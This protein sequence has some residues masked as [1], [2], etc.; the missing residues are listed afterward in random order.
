M[1][2]LC[3]VIGTLTLLF[4]CSDGGG[5]SGYV[6]NPP[7]SGFKP[8]PQNPTVD[9]ENASVEQN[10]DLTG[11]YSRNTIQ[12][13]DYIDYRL[14][15]WDDFNPDVGEN[16]SRVDIADAALYL[17][18][19]E[20]S[21]AEIAEHFDGKRDLFHMA[22]YVINNA[23]N[24]CFDSGTDSATCFTE[25]R[26]SVPPY[27]ENISTEIRENATLL[28]ADGAVMNTVDGKEFTF[29]LDTNGTISGVQLTDADDVT[30]DFKQWHNYSVD[31]DANT[32]TLQNFSY[33][34]IGRELGLSY[35][36]FGRYKITSGV[37]NANT[38]QETG[39]TT[40]GM[41]AGG[42]ESKKIAEADIVIPDTDLVLYGR[43]AATVTSGRGSEPATA[44]FTGVSNL[45]MNKDSGAVELVTSFDNWYNVVATKNIGNNDAKFTFS[46]FAE[47]GI[48]LFQFA[49][50]V[51]GKFET[52]GKMD[53]NYYAENPE[54]N[55]PTEAT[56]LA[57]VDN[58]ADDV[59][60]D[61]VFGVKQQF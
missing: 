22:V 48:Y 57:T 32:A 9:F 18:N 41:F 23:L 5:T 61:M 28:T 49:D 37:L 53:I 29:F 13:T 12:I 46:N 52:T 39:S 11:L 27:F 4:G 56:G 8:R 58:G 10:N 55:L 26:D 24:H 25:W 59:K 14:N 51:D 33:D 45:Y 60:M 43:A 6:P 54:T 3:C 50:A 7:D 38:G 15:D 36:D 2:K 47:S 1:K 31:S 19:A 16:I 44:N 17:T 42:Y 35:S 40:T 20:L 21:A 30:T 34:S